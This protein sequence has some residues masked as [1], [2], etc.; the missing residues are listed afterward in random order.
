MSLPTP[1][2]VFPAPEHNHDL[3]LDEAMVAG[4]KSFRNQRHAADAAA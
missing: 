1:S 4:E 2:P 3:C